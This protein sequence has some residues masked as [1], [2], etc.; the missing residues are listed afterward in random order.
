MAGL[1]ARLT[2]VGNNVFFVRL[3]LTYLSQFSEISLS[4]HIICE[5][6]L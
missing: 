6:F 3:I 5:W 1:L 2:E 4:K